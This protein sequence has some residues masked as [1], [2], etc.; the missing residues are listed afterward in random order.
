[1]ISKD[2]I[3]RLDLLLAAGLCI[4][5]AALCLNSIQLYWVN[6]DEG[7]YYQTATRDTLAEVLRATVPHTHPPLYYVIVWLVT[8]L[9]T[10]ILWMRMPSVIFGSLLPLGA[11]L[12]SRQV[13]GRAAA[14]ACGLLIAVS[15][16]L[17]ILSQTIRPYSLYHLLVS[18][19]L[20]GIVTFMRHPADKSGYAFF[21]WSLALLLLVHYGGVL[22]L[23]STILLMLGAWTFSAAHRAQWKLALWSLRAPGI[24]F[25]FVCAINLQ[26][27]LSEGIVRNLQVSQWRLPLYI[28]SLGSFLKNLYGAIGYIF[29]DELAPVVV[30]LILVGF[31]VLLKEQQW[32]LVG[33]FVCSLLVAALMSHLRLYPFGGSRHNAYLALLFVL[34][35]G[36]AIDFVSRST[37]GMQIFFSLP[38]IA[39]LVMGS[40]R[41]FPPSLTASNYVT[42][43][44][45]LEQVVLQS[46]LARV[47]RALQTDNTES[48]VFITQ[49]GFQLLRPLL[50]PPVAD[51]AIASL[52]SHQVYAVPDI[53]RFSALSEFEQSLGEMCEK[54]VF[55]Q[56]ISLLI[57]SQWG[58]AGILWELLTYVDDHEWLRKIV[59][60]ENLSLYELDSEAA[61][62]SIKTEESLPHQPSQN[63]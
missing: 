30:C 26:F 10:D 8:H 17:I 54:S 48:P 43:S 4:L 20:L 37:R 63:S 13:F 2:R 60:T 52:G 34:P 45:Q 39:L 46:D 18:A 35:I 55:S 59:L 53:Y 27:A 50:V 31:L 38:L 36:A 32:D 25:L 12:L 28:S 16:G 21:G 15:P 41:A 6:P 29:A 51:E 42:H 19:T 7:I 47:L 61:C 23:L 3:T 62:K 24:S 58:R 44:P 57:L 33:F 49:Q 9:S 14:I 40:R 11:Y 5:T 56:K 1:M 22:I